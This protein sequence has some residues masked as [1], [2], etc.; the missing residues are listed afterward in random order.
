VDPKQLARNMGIA[1][2]VFGLGFMLLP[3]LTGRVWIGGEA[4][5]DGPRILTQAIGARDL[6]MGLG[7]LGAMG[8]NRPVKGWLQMTA[9]T[10]AL[11]FV[12]GLV[13]GARIPRWNRRILLALAG[14]SAA[15]GVVAAQGIDDGP[16]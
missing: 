12:A 7:I 14:S 16:S 4:Q 2:I 15:Q 11:D 3:G 1:R 6:V 13:A 5:R 9:L 8:S 10:D